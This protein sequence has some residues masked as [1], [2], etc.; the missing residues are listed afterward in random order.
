MI[1]AVVAIGTLIAVCLI[2]DVVLLILIKIL[3]KYHPSE[4][5]TGRFEAG[6]VPLRAPRWVLPMQYFGFMFLF[7]AAEPIL[8]LLLVLS[9]L[10]PEA[11]L[12]LLLILLILLLPT[13]YVGY[14]MAEE[15]AGVR[16]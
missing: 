13:I 16:R 9:L 8:V 6:N 11:F 14:K 10:S 2:T 5:K 12:P 4:L 7:M 3:P 1:D 15:I